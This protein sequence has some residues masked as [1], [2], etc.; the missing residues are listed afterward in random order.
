M[1]NEKSQHPT[2]LSSAVA[3]LQVGRR[4]GSLRATAQGE[5]GVPGGYGSPE[6]RPLARLARMDACAG[7][8]S[9]VCGTGEWQY[10]L[11]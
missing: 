7:V 6:K 8:V 2:E 9:T 10:V 1:E 3:R 11:P 5:S 4:C